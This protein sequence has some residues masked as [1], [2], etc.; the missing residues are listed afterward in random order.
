LRFVTK[1]ANTA[2][3]YKHGVS[4]HNIPKPHAI[5]MSKAICGF[6]KFLFIH[7]TIPSVDKQYAFSV[8]LII[9]GIGLSQYGGGDPFYV[10]AGFGTVAIASVWLLI[11]IVKEFKKK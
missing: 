2:G 8:I 7:G 9:L 1:V 4:N 10:G 11:R 3:R 6:L 5:E